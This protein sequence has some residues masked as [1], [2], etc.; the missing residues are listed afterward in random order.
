MGETLPRLPK[1]T[2]KVKDHGSYVKDEIGQIP[3]S[4]PLA[5]KAMEKAKHNYGHSEFLLMKF[6]ELYNR[7]IR[8]DK[9]IARLKDDCQRGEAALQEARSQIQDLIDKFDQCDEERQELMIQN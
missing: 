1:E 4:N 5:V 8:R 7:I 9:K 2:N 6:D 3:M